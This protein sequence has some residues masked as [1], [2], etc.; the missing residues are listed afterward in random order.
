[1]AH[2]VFLMEG[3]QTKGVGPWESG[4]FVVIKNSL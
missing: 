3:P 2:D 1:M 4:V